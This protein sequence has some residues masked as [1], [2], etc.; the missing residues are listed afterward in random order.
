MPA[1]GLSM[2]KIK[3]VLRQ[4]WEQGLSNRQI[5]AACGV[6]R[7]TVSEYLR[8]IAE[9]GLNWPLPEDLSEARLEQLLFPSPPDLPTQIREIRDWQ[10]I[11]DG[12]EGKHVTLF[13]L[14]QAHREATPEGYHYSWFCE[15][16]QV[17]HDKLNLV[18]RQ[19]YRAGEKLLV[20]YA[21]QTVPA[22]NRT[23]GEIL[24]AQIFVA[25][26]GASN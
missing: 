24:D 7:P 18:M 13:L 21:G 9:A 15:H 16:Y 19:D 2:R 26:M 3:V 8:R 6:S 14:W 5:A 17:W 25:V 12:L 23:T 22:M 11:H 20:D 10:Q 1:K 4:K